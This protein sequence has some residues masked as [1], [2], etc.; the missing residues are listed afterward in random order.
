MGMSSK[1]KMQQRMVCTGVRLS[2]E[3]M[4]DQVNAPRTPE[5]VAMTFISASIA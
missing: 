2:R 5:R 4:R 3:D 1:R